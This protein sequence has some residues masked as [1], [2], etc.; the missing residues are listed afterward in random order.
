MSKVF[1]ITGTQIFFYITFIWCWYLSH[2]NEGTLREVALIVVCSF[3]LI[4]AKLDGIQN[5]LENEL[6]NS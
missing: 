3:C 1:E 5:R 6:D 4:M 2:L